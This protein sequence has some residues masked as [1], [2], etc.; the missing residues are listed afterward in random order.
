MSNEGKIS[1]KKTASQW[2]AKENLVENE[3]NYISLGTKRRQ[4][5]YVG[6]T[7]K[8]RVKILIESGKY[9]LAT[10]PLPCQD[11]RAKLILQSEP[12]G[13]TLIVR[14]H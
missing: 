2:L 10:T 11:L 3:F 13:P 5:K 6:N 12:K 9:T 7:V 4:S 14:E 8:C 1:H